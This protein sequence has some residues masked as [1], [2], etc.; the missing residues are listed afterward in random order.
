MYQLFPDK[1]VQCTSINIPCRNNRQ[2]PSLVVSPKLPKKNAP[3]I[4]WIHGGGY[5]AGMK[6]MVHTSRAIDLVKN[7]GATVI[8]PGYRLSFVSFLHKE[9]DDEETVRIKSDKVLTAK[10]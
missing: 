8:S 5:M 7:Y 1:D 3:G 2:M 9:P 10:S 6:E 4:L